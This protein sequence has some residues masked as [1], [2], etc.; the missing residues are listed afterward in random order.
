MLKSGCS[1]LAWVSCVVLLSRWSP[2]WPLQRAREYNILRLRRLITTKRGICWSRSRMLSFVIHL[3]FY[4]VQMLQLNVQMSWQTLSHVLNFNV[5]FIHKSC[6]H[7]III[8]KTNNVYVTLK[9]KCQQNLSSISLAFRF[10]PIFLRASTTF[11][12]DKS[13]STLRHSWKVFLNAVS[14]LWSASIT[15]SSASA[16]SSSPISLSPSLY[17][18][19]VCT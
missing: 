5:I 10:S 7:K 17:H 18:L 11:C 15:S 14:P 9:I 6:V 2:R 19:V 3:T 4:P 1:F 8:D 13:G 12:H 16:S